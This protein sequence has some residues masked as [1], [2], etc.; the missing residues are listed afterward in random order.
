M[1]QVAERRA[2]KFFGEGEVVWRSGDRRE[3]SRMVAGTA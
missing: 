1:T 2:E 3:R